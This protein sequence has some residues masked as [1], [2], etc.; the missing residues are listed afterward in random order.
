MTKPSCSRG[1][2]ISICA[3]VYFVS[4]F[5]RKSFAAAMA[6]MLAEQ[7]ID[8]VTAGLIGTLLFVFYGIGQL[9]SGYL[10]DKIRPLYLILAGLSTTALCNLL[11]PLLPNGA[12]MIPVWGL[13]GLAQAMLWPPILKLLST[14]LDYEGYALGSMVVTCAAHV[15][16]IIL[17][18]FVPIALTFMSWEAVFYAAAG[19]TVLS[20]LAFVLLMHLILPASPTPALPKQRQ[21]KEKKE[22]ENACTLPSLLFHSGILPILGAIITCG[23]LRDGIESWLPTLYSEAFG[24]DAS[25]STLVSAILPV[26]ALAAVVL[27]TVFHK[28]SFFSNEARG[29]AVLFILSALL[30]VPFAILIEVEAT[31]AR[32]VCLIL[33]VLVCAAMHAVNMLLIS[34]LPG[35]FAAMGKTAT[36]GGLVNAFIYIGAA[37]SMYGIALVSEHFGWL[38]TVLSWIGVAAAGALLSLLACKKYSAFLATKG[39]T[40]EA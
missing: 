1:G 11:M 14:Y 4:Y 21:V 19:L 18:L 8:K 3:L 32:F 22:E 16:T 15:S 35:R 7:I 24:R 6:G 31:V 9:V 13:N 27:I 25:E 23:F 40:H 17:Y 26:F 37:S 34:F 33:A 30:C 5:S 36:V 29:A 39:E 2:I 12:W 10:G 38:T 20:M 28:K